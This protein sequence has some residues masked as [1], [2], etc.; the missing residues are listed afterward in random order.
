[1]GSSEFAEVYVSTETI[2]INSIINFQSILYTF[3]LIPILAKYFFLCFVT[4][5]EAQR[6][7]SSL[8]TLQWCIDRPWA[9][10]W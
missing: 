1:M 4:W 3:F 6:R 8:L 10:A 7:Q 5:E 2:I 9:K